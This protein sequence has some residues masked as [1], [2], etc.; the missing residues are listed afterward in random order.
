MRRLPS[1]VREAAGK[2]WNAERLSQALPERHPA[3]ASMFGAG[4]GIALMFTE[5]RILVAALRTL[6]AQGVPALPMHDGIMVPRS[7]SNQAMIAMADASEGI[8][9]APLAVAIE[10]WT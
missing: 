6:M 9:G 7:K 2:R 10:A 8:A 3:I 5:S 1:E 4:L